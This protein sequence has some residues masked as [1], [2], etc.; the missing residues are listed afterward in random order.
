VTLKLR[1]AFLRGWFAARSQ[2]AMPAPDGMEEKA[3]IDSGFDAG[4]KSSGAALPL[5]DQVDPGDLRAAWQMEFDIEKARLQK[6]YLDVLLPGSGRPTL[7]LDLRETAAEPPP[8]A[9]APPQPKSRWDEED[10]DAPPANRFL[11]QRRFAPA[12]G[13]KVRFKG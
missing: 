9:L 3:Y 13:R 4:K 12:N 7:D 8:E 10:E 2:R 6:R 5:L 11:P 1:N